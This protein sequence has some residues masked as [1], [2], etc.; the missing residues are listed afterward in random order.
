MNEEDPVKVPDVFQPFVPRVV[1]R[2]SGCCA[3]P[4][5]SIRAGDEPADEPVKAVLVQNATP[6]ATAASDLDD[7][8]PIVGSTEEPCREASCAARVRERAIELAGEACARALH[9][10]IAKNPLFVARF[11]DDAIEAAGRTSAKRVRL[12]PADAAACSGRVAIDVVADET[13]ASGE[14]VVE[15]ANGTAGATIDRRA[16]LLV[17]AM[18]ER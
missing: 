7:V 16:E 1:S 8:T 15:S 11:V 18:A 10:A 2:R 17:R 12:S 3:I 5:D 4:E 13:V 9:E 6:G 14:V